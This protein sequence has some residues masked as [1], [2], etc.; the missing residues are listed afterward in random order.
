[1]SDVKETQPASA[2]TRDGLFLPM[3][4]AF[5]DEL[6]DHHDRR[7]R[8]FKTSR[9][10]TALSKKMYNAFNLFIF[11]RLY[12][13]TPLT[14][15]FRSK[16]K[17]WLR[18]VE[19]F[20]LT[21]HRVRQLNRPLPNSVAMEVESRLAAINSM[22]VSLSEDLSGMNSWRYRRQISPGIQEYIEAISLQ[23]YLQS[24]VLIS[25]EEAS[26]LIASGVQLTEDDYILGIF[27]LI[28]ELM[29]FG[30]TAMATS[31]ALP[32]GQSS[33]S[34]G[35]NDQDIG[36]QPE[37]PKSNILVDMRSLRTYFEALDTAPRVSSSGYFAKDFAKKVEVMK[38]CVEKVESV[39]YGMTVRGRERPK[40][41]VPDT[42]GAGIRGPEY[43]TSDDR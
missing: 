35:G 13:L 39:V 21:L 19:P 24:Q 4:E 17:S 37:T 7:E 28:G 27:D 32:G 43:G 20:Q 31:G 10:I 22:F 25:P 1:M 29:R 26:A 2:A 6:N 30:I 11:P 34:T 36:I 42:S 9:D 40:G 38:S 8:V 12:L 5:R 3:F 41:W 15:Y 14:A 18:W 16:G 33:D 23:H